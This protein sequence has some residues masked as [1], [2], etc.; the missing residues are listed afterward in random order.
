MDSTGSRRGGGAGDWTIVQIKC[1]SYPV[2]LNE[3]VE[4]GVA[5]CAAVSSE[6]QVHVRDIL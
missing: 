1:I 5:L 3:V 2:R 4:G 6:Q